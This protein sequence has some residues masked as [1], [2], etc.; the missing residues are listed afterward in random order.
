[1]KVKEL[2]RATSLPETFAI[3]NLA[4]GECVV[5]IAEN[6]TQ[7]TSYAPDGETAQQKTEYVYDRT[8]NTVY[9]PD[10]DSAVAAFVALKYTYADEFALMRKGMNDPQNAEY[11]AYVAYVEIC[12]QFCRTKFTT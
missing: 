2:T 12:K 5:S 11:L 4:T 10:Y 8:Y 7:V 9:A 3:E 6:V 1:M